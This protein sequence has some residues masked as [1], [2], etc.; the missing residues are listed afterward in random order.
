MRKITYLDQ[1]S[2][3][4]KVIRKCE[5]CHVAMVSPDGDPYLVPFNFGYADGYIYLHSDPKGMKIDYLKNNPKVCINFTTDHDLFHINKEV[6]CS[7]GMRYRSVIVNGEVEFIDTIEEK[8][9]FLNVFMG[10]YVEGGD[11]TYS[12]P[13]LTNVCVM[14]VK[15]ENFKGK[16]YGYQPE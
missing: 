15:V 3:V 6:A 7:Y 11:F 12:G 10:Q 4:E 1:L 2:Q 14:R 9:R 13:A 16:L 8:E 5:V